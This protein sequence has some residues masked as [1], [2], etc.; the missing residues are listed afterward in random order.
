MTQATIQSTRLTLRAYA[1]SDQGDVQ[2]LANEPL[3]FRHLHAPEVPVRAADAAEHI[4]SLRDSALLHPGFGTWRIST[5]TGSFLGEAFLEPVPGCSFIHF[6]GIL[7][8]RAW[9][10]GY[11][12]EATAALFE[13]SFTHLG[14]DA[15]A[16]ITHI[17][18]RAAASCN[19]LCGMQPFRNFSYFGT[20]VTAHV[21]THHRWRQWRV[22][23]VAADC[24]TNVRKLLRLARGSASDPRPEPHTAPLRPAPCQP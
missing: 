23:L 3:V 22:H 11:A 24:A 16:A 2:S 15:I 7:L 8:P 9:G 12:L 19:R 4:F 10:R 1:P 17:E 13:Y 21:L 18:N 6:G 20:P 5:H 14:V